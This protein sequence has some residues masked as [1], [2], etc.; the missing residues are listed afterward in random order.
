L[1]DA[2]TCGERCAEFPA[3]LPVPS[4]E[5][6]TTVSQF[7]AD[8]QRERSSAEAIACALSDVYAAISEELGEEAE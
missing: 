4:R 3:C 7:S 5:I 2:V 6:L 8:M 1:P